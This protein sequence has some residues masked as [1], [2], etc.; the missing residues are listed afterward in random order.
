MIRASFISGQVRRSRAHQHAHVLNR[1]SFM[2]I[3]TTGQRLNSIPVLC[4]F[5]LL[6]LVPVSRSQ[7]Q[8]SGVADRSTFEVA[9]IKPSSPTPGPNDRRAFGLDRT[10]TAMGLPLATLVSLA[11]RVQGYQISGGPRWIYADRYDI[12]AQAEANS[13][14]DQFSAMLQKLLEDRF[15]LRFHRE[16][17][18]L[19]VYVLVV[20]KDGPKLKKSSEDENYSLRVSGNQWTFVHLSMAGL[21]IRLSRELGRTVVDQTELPGS[22]SFT[23]QW[24][25]DLVPLTSVDGIPGRTA[26]ETGG[27][28]LFTAVQEQLGLRLDSRKQ[29]IE[30]IIIDNADR[31]SE[32]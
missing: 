7:T 28:S 29:P 27:P 8:S 18:D 17:K 6:C 26:P 12:V 4:A 13:S 11:Y 20:G 31:P 15:E 25:R 2:R 9:S 22:F 24:S 19:P 23:L 10:Y 32:N 14:S 3:L 30:M 16:V 1:H 5:S 21:A